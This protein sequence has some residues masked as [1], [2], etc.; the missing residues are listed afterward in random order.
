MSK[1]L[2]LPSLSLP[3]A[4]PLSLPAPPLSLTLLGL[5]LLTAAVVEVQVV[6]GDLQA[7]WYH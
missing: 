6:C 4:P 3:P 5:L 2:S 7:T 1:I